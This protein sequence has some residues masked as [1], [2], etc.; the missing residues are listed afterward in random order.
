[1]RVPHSVQ[2]MNELISSVELAEVLGVDTHWEHKS[3]SS[4]WLHRVL[5]LEQQV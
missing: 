2:G 3:F 5:S 4:L 1:M